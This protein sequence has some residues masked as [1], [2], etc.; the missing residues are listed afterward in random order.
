MQL[1]KGLFI[2]AAL[3]VAHANATVVEKN[4]M[5]QHVP[6]EATPEP[7]EKGYSLQEVNFASGDV[8][9]NGEDDEE[10][11]SALPIIGAVGACAVVGVLAAVYVKRRNEEEK[12]P[13]E[14][15]TIDDKNSVLLAATVPGAA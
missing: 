3:C 4:G 15:F 7:V 2:A 8:K 10:S 9:E 6:D 14:I 11:S 13:G 1:I 12:L 5:N